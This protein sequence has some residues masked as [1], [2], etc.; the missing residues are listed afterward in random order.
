M[1][2]DDVVLVRARTMLRSQDRIDVAGPE[3]TRRDVMRMPLESSNPYGIT[4]SSIKSYL[5]E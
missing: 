4:I 2:C 1:K 3:V 5:R